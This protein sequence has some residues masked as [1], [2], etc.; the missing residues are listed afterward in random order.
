MCAFR[1][2]TLVVCSYT[3]RNEK[4][5]LAADKIETNP[6][7]RALAKLCLNSF[8]GRLGMREDLPKTEYVTEYDRFIDLLTSNEYTV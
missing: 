8:W 1:D 7:R 6:G 2:L 5:K 4:V 3:Y